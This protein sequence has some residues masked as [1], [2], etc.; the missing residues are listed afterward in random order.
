MGRAAA[1]PAMPCGQGRVALHIAS[2]P[3]V[4]ILDDDLVRP[5][6][7]PK[8]ADAAAQGAVAAGEVGRGLR[9]AEANRAAM[10]FTLDHSALPPP[11][12]AAARP[13][14]RS[15]SRR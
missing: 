14:A 3:A 2:K 11:M 12:Q 6:I 15:G 10:T 9:Q 13:P 8:A 1:S 5:I 4:R 7:A